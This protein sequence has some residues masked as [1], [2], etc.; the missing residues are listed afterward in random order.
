MGDIGVIGYVGLRNITVQIA[1]LSGTVILFLDKGQPGISGICRPLAPRS[2][3]GR[4]YCDCSAVALLVRTL[5]YGCCR[6]GAIAKHLCI[7]KFP[8]STLENF[9]SISRVH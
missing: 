2:L 5:I 3:T 8:F 7:Q 6:V 4:K 1:A 9:A